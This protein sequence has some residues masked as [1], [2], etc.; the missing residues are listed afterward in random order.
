MTTM[1]FSVPDDVKA[2]FNE[3]FSGENKS[4]VIVQLRRD[5]IEK[6]HRRRNGDELVALSERIRAA[7]KTYTDEEIHD[8]R[9]EGR[10]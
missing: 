3:T 7:G 9:Q 4:A 5:A 10:P 1:N 2:A 8:L 6:R